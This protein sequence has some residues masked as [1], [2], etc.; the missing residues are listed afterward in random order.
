ML[1][2]ADGLGI[3]LIA[4]LIVTWASRES[5]FKSIVPWKLAEPALFVGMTVTF[6]WLLFGPFTDASAPVLR[7]YMIFPILILLAFRFDPRYW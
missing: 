4:P 3:I 1:E 7:N 5:I 2:A 6:A